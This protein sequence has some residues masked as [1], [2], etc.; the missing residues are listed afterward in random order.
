M[1]GGDADEGGLEDSLGSRV[2]SVQWR[3][4]AIYIVFL[5]VFSLAVLNSR[6][7]TY[8]Y[9]FNYYMKDLFIEEE[10]PDIAIR[11]TFQDVATVD[12]FWEFMQGP[13][14]AGLFNLSDGF[15]PGEGFIYGVNRLLGPVRVRT[16]RIDKDTCRI[17]DEMQAYIPHCYERY[18]RNKNE[19]NASFGLGAQQWRFYSS[20]ELGINNQ[21]ARLH[22]YDGGGFVADFH[23]NSTK[24]PAELMQDLID[25]QFVDLQTRA[26]FIDFSSYNGNV[27]LF[28]VAQ[29]VFEFL[30]SGGVLPSYTFRVLRLWKYPLTALGMLQL[31][32][33]LTIVV[34]VIGYLSHE[35]YKMTH[36]TDQDKYLRNPWNYFDLVNLALFVV[37]FTLRGVIIYLFGF[38]VIDVN[39][40]DFFNFQTLSFLNSAEYNCQGINAIFLWFKLFKYVEFSKNMSLI[41]NVVFKA[42]APVL[43]F[44]MMFLVV[45]MGFAQSGYLAFGADVKGFGTLTETFYTLI[46]AMLG[47]FDFEGMRRSN[48]L[49]GPIY[50]FVYMVMVFFILLSMFLAIID[51]TYDRVKRELDSQPSVHFVEKFRL[52]I[53]RKLRLETL[54]EKE[55]RINDMSEKMK[56]SNKKTL[57]KEQ[58]RLDKW[59]FKK[60]DKNNDGVLDQDELAAAHADVTRRRERVIEEFGDDDDDEVASVISMLSARGDTGANSMIQLAALANSE[61][62][63]ARLEM[64][65]DKMEIMLGKM[66]LLLL[67]Q[68]Y[69]PPSS[70]SPGLRAG[71]YI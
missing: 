41:S 19:N 42:A 58:S 40:T 29:L 1:I 49:F 3:E 59:E 38:M 60:L 65:E 23:V 70:A 11:K 57:T 44:M 36:Q 39:G 17:P 68:E 30:P 5:T 62:V 8:S 2:K 47:E 27:N 21:Q 32:G 26:V 20:D 22:K 46:R 63:N 51:E 48:R 50:F 37:G 55:A 24:P 66:D 33:E 28:H 71:S 14:L 15:N 18:Y 69:I 13:L 31:I 34:F 45:L 7:P 4:I 61:A 35:I 53:M 54:Q 43:S 25:G 52:M 16:V 10:F 6:D 67:E 64:L 12:E 56:Q 9:L